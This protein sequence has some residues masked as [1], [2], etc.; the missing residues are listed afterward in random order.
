MVSVEFGSINNFLIS[1]FSV[2][3]VGSAGR[4]VVA[5]GPGH[6]AQ[7]TAT[8]GEARLQSGNLPTA[9]LHPSGPGLPHPMPL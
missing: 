5:S 7:G 6:H 4:F 1:V 2:D 8:L 3:G 9:L